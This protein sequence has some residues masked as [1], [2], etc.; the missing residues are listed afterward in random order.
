MQGNK[1]EEEIVNNYQT[2]K[3]GQNVPQSLSE[4]LASLK[5]KRKEVPIKLPGI[6]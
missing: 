5:K 4:A 6:N 2:A 3:F 1:A